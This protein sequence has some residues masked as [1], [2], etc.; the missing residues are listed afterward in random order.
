MPIYAFQ[1][2]SCDSTFEL[3]LGIAQFP[4]HCPLCSA[5]HS[6]ITKCPTRFSTIG[7][8]KNNSD[9][10]TPEVPHSKSTQTHS[11]CHTHTH[12]SQHAACNKHYIDGLLKKYDNSVK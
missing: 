1:C 6:R 10:V 8:S 12:S 9:S 4:D 2:N 3:L 5:D 11:T 7:P